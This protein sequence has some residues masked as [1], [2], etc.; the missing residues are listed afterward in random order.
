MKKYFL[1]FLISLTNVSGA[2]LDGFFHAIGKVESNN[3]DS[4]IGDNGRAIGRF[5]IWEVYYRDAKEYSLRRG[6]SFN[7]KNTIYTDCRNPQIA[8]RVMVAY[9]T[10]YAPTA[11]KNNDFEILARLHNSGPAWK[12]KI[13]KS[14]SYWLKVKYA[15]DSNKVPK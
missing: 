5:Q 13:S 4:A 9:W 14:D 1:I 7:L 12:A 11:L 15:L 6:D 3:N 10:R 8:K 2:D